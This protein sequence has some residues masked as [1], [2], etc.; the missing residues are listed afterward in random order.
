ME[1]EVRYEHEMK[2][3][4]TRLDGAHTIQEFK[5]VREEWYKLEGSRSVPTDQMKEADMKLSELEANVNV[6]SKTMREAQ[7]MMD[8]LVR[9]RDASTKELSIAKKKLGT[10]RE[11]KYIKNVMEWQEALKDATERHTRDC[12]KWEDALKEASN[13]SKQMKKVQRMLER[14]LATREMPSKDMEEAMRKLDLLEKEE[15]DAHGIV[16]RHAG[17]TLYKLEEELMRFQGEL[18]VTKKLI[19]KAVDMSA[20]PNSFDDCSSDEE[21]EEGDDEEERDE[22]DSHYGQPNCYNWI[23]G[24]DIAEMPSG[25][26]SR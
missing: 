14:L 22:E 11:K 26:D 13:D 24:L 7:A 9:K 5:M 16:L 23:C 6:P 17:S 18:N 4:Q 2:V 25:G 8:E 20:L 19:G 1:R 15:K 10:K 21:E 12:A 3:W